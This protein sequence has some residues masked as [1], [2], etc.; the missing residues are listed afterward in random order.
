MIA[1]YMNRRDYENDIR[2]LLM[3]FFYG[4]KIV[5]NAKEWDVCL[6]GPLYGKL[7]IIKFKR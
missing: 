6:D 1:L 7:H 2:S 5:L 4:D 3:A